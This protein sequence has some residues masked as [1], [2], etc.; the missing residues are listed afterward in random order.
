MS[1][2]FVRIH[3][4]LMESNFDGPLFVIDSKRKDKTELDKSAFNFKELTQPNSLVSLP[5]AKRNS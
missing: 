4:I 5:K 3:E 2:N 1:W